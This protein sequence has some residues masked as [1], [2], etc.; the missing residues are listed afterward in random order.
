MLYRI[1]TN[2]SKGFLNLSIP[3][4]FMIVHLI[5]TTHFGKPFHE[6]LIEKFSFFPL[7]GFLNMQFLLLSKEFYTKKEF[8]Q[9]NFL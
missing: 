4:G 9:K 3:V 1:L 6:R 5:L 7:R 8:I 2:K